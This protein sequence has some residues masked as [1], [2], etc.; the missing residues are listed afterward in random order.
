[1]AQSIFYRR[2]IRIVAADG[3]VFRG[4]KELDAEK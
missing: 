2:V 3:V 1:M 4:A